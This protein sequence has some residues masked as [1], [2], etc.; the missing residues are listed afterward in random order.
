[1]ASLV[2]TNFVYFYTT[3]IDMMITYDNGVFIERRSYENTHCIR[4]ARLPQNLPQSVKRD[5]LVPTNF[6]DHPGSCTII[7]DYKITWKQIGI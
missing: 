4:V 1:M 3:S 2:S 5:I 7:S 6:N